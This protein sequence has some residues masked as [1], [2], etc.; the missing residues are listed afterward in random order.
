GSR[1]N[2][3]NEVDFTALGAFLRGAVIWELASAVPVIGW[4][5]V[6]PVGLLISL[7]GALFS[8]LRWMPKSKT[9]I[10]TA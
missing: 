7:G 3:R 9:E 5:L 10:K 4:L 6:I 1:L 8:V 2:Q